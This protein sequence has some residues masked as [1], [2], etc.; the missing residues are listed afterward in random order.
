MNPED[1]ALLERI[2]KLTEENN[3]ILKSIHRTNKIGLAIKVL[4]WVVILGL[5][6]GAFYFVQPYINSLTG[7]L[8]T[9]GGTNNTGISPYNSYTENI[10]DLL[11]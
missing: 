2:Y 1:K 4:Y 8:D 10:M 9:K 5:S 7:V 3:T 11:K 6:F